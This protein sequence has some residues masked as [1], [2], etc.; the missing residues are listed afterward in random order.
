M[1]DQNDVLKIEKEATKFFQTATTPVLKI[2]ALIKGTVNGTENSC[3][4]V[5]LNIEISDPQILIGEKGQTL[6]EI[7]KLL[8]VILNKKIKKIFYLNLD[9]NS[10]KKKKED[11]LKDFAKS[12]ADEASVSKKEKTLPPMS[13]Y[14]RKIIHTEV[15]KRNDV[16]AES[17][18]DGLERR[19]IIKPK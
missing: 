13:S 19:I 5:D 8:R 11:Y 4:V 9:I 18:G 15:S 12:A 3:E 7:Q 17:F 14:E 10:Y 16:I 2:E 6:F 1:L